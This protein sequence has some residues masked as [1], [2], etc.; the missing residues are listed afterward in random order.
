MRGVVLSFINSGGSGLAARAVP[1]PYSGT[2]SI[3]SR[4]KARVV[5]TE[6]DNLVSN[7]RGEV[8]EIIISWTLLRQ[9][10]CDARALHTPDLVSDMSNPTLV[11]L[12]ILAAKLRD[13]IVARLS[14]LGEKKIGRLTFYFAKVK[15]GVLEAETA[16]FARFI[17]KTGLSRKRNHDISHKELPEKW[18]DHRYHH[19]PYS[20]VTR[21]VAFAMR[22]MKQIDRHYLGPSSP[23]LWAELRKKRYTPTAPPRVGFLLLPHMR[24]PALTRARIIAEEERE[25]KDVW[26]EMTTKVDGVPTMVKVSR[27]W[28]AVLLHGGILMLNDYP[29]NSLESITSEQ[30]ASP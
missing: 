30:T 24:L 29:L 3:M 23:F 11:R 13:E 17:E 4:Q 18:T 10:M 9:T 7:L 26:S 2:D 25:G 6:V 5:N 21:G 27:E 16:A 19:I 1:Q 14:E 22:L 8:G 12:E 20:V 15:L 28:G